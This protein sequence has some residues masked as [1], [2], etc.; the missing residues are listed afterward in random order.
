[1]SPL[2]PSFLGRYSRVISLWMCRAWCY[3]RTFLVSLSTVSSSV[4]VQS[5]TGNPYDSAG[6]AYE[7]T[8]EMIL[9]LLSSLLRIIFNRLKYSFLSAAFEVLSVTWCSLKPRYRYCLFWSN[10]FKISPLFSVIFSLFATFPRLIVTFTF[11]LT[12][13]YS[14]THTNIV[15]ECFDDVHLAFQLLVIWSVEFQI[16]HKEKVGY[17]DFLSDAITELAFFEKPR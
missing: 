8:A 3:W 15:A 9:R 2:P 13:I 1:M 10:V 4:I 12:F 7:M 5:S 17:G 16:V 11:L 6:T 14:E